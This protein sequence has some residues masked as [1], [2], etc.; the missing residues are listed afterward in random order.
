MHAAFTAGL[1]HLVDA[2][3]PGNP[4][5]SKS[6]NMLRLLVSSLYK[7]NIAWFW[8]NRSIMVIE[9]LAEQWGVGLR[10]EGQAQQIDEESQRSFE[11][12]NLL[13]QGSYPTDAAQERGV[14][15]Q[16]T[17][18]NTLEGMGFFDFGLDLD[19][20]DLGR[21]YDDFCVPEG[22]IT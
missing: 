1:V 21:L 7:M 5:P 9:S 4:N 3:D 15:S 10:D 14:F 22:Q 20:F 17:S 2:K 18:E 13:V 12:Y 16:P 6:L 8:C 11:R 19:F